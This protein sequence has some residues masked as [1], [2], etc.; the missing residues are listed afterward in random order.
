MGGEGDPG[1]GSGP[2][3][4]GGVD[5]E[6]LLAAGHDQF[7]FGDR[8]VG[9]RLEG[10]ADAAADGVDVACEVDLDL[11]AEAGDEVGEFVA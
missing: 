3:E 8:G 2:A 4:V 7:E 6:A 1:T 9:D 10:V 11:A 5:E